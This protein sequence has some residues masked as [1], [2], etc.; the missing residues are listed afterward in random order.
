MTNLVSSDRGWNAWYDNMPGLGSKAIYVTGGIDIPDFSVSAVIEKEPSM[1]EA[2][3]YL[4]LVVVITTIID[5]SVRDKS[6]VELQYKEEIEN[7]KYVKVFVRLP[8]GSVVTIEEV[9][10]VD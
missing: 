8:D 1:D 2:G 5:S 6:F 9:T 7:E 3:D 4:R 10:S